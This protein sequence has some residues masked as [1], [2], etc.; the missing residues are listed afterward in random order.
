MHN[1]FTLVQWIVVHTLAKDV[2]SSRDSRKEN[3]SIV[4]FRGWHC[5]PDDVSRGSVSEMRALAVY[6]HGPRFRRPRLVLL[7]VL[8]NKSRRAMT[9]VACPAYRLVVTCWQR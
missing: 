5:S 9:T 7:N 3:T 4:K 6:A 1:E 8:R 2:A